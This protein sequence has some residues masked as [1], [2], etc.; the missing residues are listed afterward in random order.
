MEQAGCADRLRVRRRAHE[1]IAVGTAVIVLRDQ[2]PLHGGNLDLASGFSFE[3]LVEFLNRRVFLWPGTALS[4]NDY[5]VRHFERY[6]QEHPVLLRVGFRSLCFSNPSAC[7]LYCRYNSG[8]P[9]C[10]QGRRS[11]RG[12]DTFVS[13]AEFG[14]TPGQVV[15]LAFCTVVELPTDAEIGIHPNGP[16]RLFL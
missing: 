5:G 10:S 16:W 8:A 7:P 15:E 4:P 12:P 1:R 13:A 6:Q 11:P 2:G 14:G 3:D 9:R